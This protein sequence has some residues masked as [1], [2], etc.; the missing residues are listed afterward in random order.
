MDDKD[1]DAYVQKF[2]N[3]FKRTPRVDNKS[4]QQDFRYNTL[5]IDQDYFIPVRDMAAPNPIETLPGATNLSDIADIEFLHKKLLTALRVPKAFLGFE[6]AAGDGK[7]LSLQDVRFART[8]N[9]IQQSMIRELN[10]IAIIH[11]YILGLEDEL[12]NFQLFL[13]N[14][15]TQ[16]EMMKIEEWKEKVL[17]YKDMTQP[18]EGGIAPTSHTFAKK[19]I[20]NFSEDEIILD[21]ERQR[22]E[23]AAGTELENTSKIIKKTGIFDKIDRLYGVVPDESVV[24]SGEKEDD[25]MDNMGDSMSMGGGG[26]FSSPSGGFGDDLGGEIPD[27][28]DDLGGEI[29]DLGGEIPDLATDLEQTDTELPPTDTEFGESFNNDKFLDNLLIDNVKRNS[30]ITQLINEIN[31]LVKE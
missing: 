9:K 23:R 10:K 22:I 21:L 11:L 15:S 3:K 20:F 27:L 17:L 6:E 1:V 12:D 14:P 13:T 16:G 2:A 30:D 26:S 28:G 7:N 31:K 5:S 29:P 19:Q 24:E 18:I 8:I 4:G 25:D